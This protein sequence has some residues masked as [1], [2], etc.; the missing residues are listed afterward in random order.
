MAKTLIVIGGGAAGFFCAVN[1]ARLNPSLKVIILE[2]SNKLLSKVRISGGGRC[3]VT[4]ACFSIAEM[5]HRYPRG[6][7]FVK[8]T[9]HEFFTTDTIEWFRERGV[10]IIEE[11]DGRMFP[12]TNSSETIVNCLLREASK[13]NVEIILGAD[14]K[15]IDKIGNIHNIGNID[16]I[17]TA[18]AFQLTCANEK[19]YTA[20]AVCVATGGYPK[21]SMFAW[22]QSLGHSF[23]TPVPSLFTFN[24]PNHPISRLMGV[25]VDHARIR[26]TGTKL[27]QTGPL[28]ITHWGFSG[29]GILRS[30]AW[31]A[32]LLAEKDWRFDIQVNWLPGLNEQELKQKFQEL[33]FAIAAKSIGSKNPFGLPNRLWDFF[34][35]QVGIKPEIR[36]ADLPAKEQNKLI[37][38]ISAGEFSIAGKTTYKDEFVTAGGIRL[39]EVEP[40]TCMSRKV[41]NIYFAGEIL[42]VDGITGGYNFQHAWTSGFIV[43]KAQG[44]WINRPEL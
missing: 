15:R 13:Y 11:P 14:V 8:K 30:S 21:S 6:A 26:I 39:D 19:I 29:P 3:N 35:E 4:H 40:S 7:N 22:L 9:F 24:M 18:P 12:A 43:A 32:R 17:H 37:R 27:E 20:D 28:L 41:S 38:Q 10:A 25:S 16:S 33:R 1:A 2:R 36:W 5:T 42:D 34:L 44:T 23:E 31:G